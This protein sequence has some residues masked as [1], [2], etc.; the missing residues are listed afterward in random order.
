MPIVEIRNGSF[1]IYIRRFKRVCEE[2][3]IMTKLRE[4]ESYEKL[5]D[6]R[7]RKRGMAIKRHKK[8][9]QKEWEILERER[10]RLL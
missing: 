5:T 3:L 8:K 10:R 1:E 7:R 4:K 2:A 6:K 9:L